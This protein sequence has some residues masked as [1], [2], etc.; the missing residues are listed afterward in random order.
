MN[1]AKNVRRKLSILFLIAAMLVTLIPTA[2][3]FAET[4]PT[5]EPTESCSNVT[6]IAAGSYQA[7]KTEKIG[8]TGKVNVECK[9]IRIAEGKAFA[10]VLFTSATYPY[11]TVNVDGKQTAFTTTSEAESNIY[12]KGTS[13]AEIPVLLNKEFEMA[14]YSQKMTTWIKY[15]IKIS[16]DEPVAP[17]V[18]TKLE[19]GVYEVLGDPDKTGSEGIGD[20]TGSK[21]FR[22]VKATMTVDENGKPAFADIYLSGTGYDAL[23]LGKRSKDAPDGAIT[24]TNENKLWTDKELPVSQ[25]FNH[26]VGKGAQDGLFHFVIPVSDFETTMDLLGKSG[27]YNQWSHKKLAFHKDKLKKIDAGAECNVIEGGDLSVKKGEKAEIKVDAALDSFFEVII[28]GEVFD[29]T[30]YEKKSGST[31]VSI[32]TSVLDE[33]KHD[34][35]LTFENGRYAKASLNVEPGAVNPNKLEKGVYKVLGN[36]D[37]TGPEGVGDTTGSKMFRL[38]KATITVDENGKP[39]FADIYL[40]GTGYDALYIGEK[41]KDA[42][43]GAITKTN[44]NKLWTDK[45]LPVSQAFNHKVGKGAQD[46]LFHFVIPVSDFET[47]M[48]LLGRS[49]NYNQWSHKKLAFHK[50]MLE[51]IDDKLTYDVL[52]GENLSVKKGD[53]AEIKVDADLDEFFEVIIDGEVF[54][55]TKYEKKSGSTVVSLDTSY[56]AEGRHDVLLS[57]A[58]GRYA[59]A[60]LNVEAGVNEN[61]PGNNNTAKP[62]DKKSA[63]NAKNK[64]V[65]NTPNTGDAGDMQLMLVVMLISFAGAFAVYK[66]KNSR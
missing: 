62:E 29:S 60:S 57:F 64:Q 53:K 28:D 16:M 33:G 12:P 9:G 14:A 10:Q 5:P 66:K 4:M 37:K 58:N 34:V 1:K 19:S 65:K 17:V 49:K 26:K 39:A 8:G 55:S 30:K 20:V 6:T 47:S 3:S 27:K 24:K 41:T 59:K 38:V 52:A 7:T 51:K 22:L 40:S 13:V 21:M 43:D 63:N 48:D 25:A 50:D 56:L 36:P 2:G 46:G 45:E 18:P 44:E 42:P 61:K 31:V 23:Y 15:K 32:D 11:F 54:D 35:K